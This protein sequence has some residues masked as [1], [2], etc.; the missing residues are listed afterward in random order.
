MGDLEP[1]LVIGNKRYSSWSLRPWLAMRMANARFNEIKVTLRQTGKT[2]ETIRLHNPSGTVPALKL[3][4]TVIA[5]SLAICEWVNDAYPQA[6]LWPENPI[7]RAI[8]RA[9]ASEMHAGFTGLRRDMPMDV[10]GSYPGQGHTPEALDDVARVLAIWNTCRK[11][12]GGA[13]PYLFGHFTITDAMFAPVVS[14]LQTYDVTVDDTSAEYIDAVWS[15][16][17]I[18]DW[19]AEAATE[20]PLPH[21]L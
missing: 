20:A 13:G 4:D 15:L 16:P 18:K 11:K 17:A 10:C 5:E 21:P 19:V 8:A 6:R 9:Y 1:T 2:A 7:A 3:G 12:F 14:R